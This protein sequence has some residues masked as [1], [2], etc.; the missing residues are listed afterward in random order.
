MISLQV[1]GDFGENFCGP[2]GLCYPDQTVTIPQIFKYLQLAHYSAHFIGFT[3]K[4]TIKFISVHTLFTKTKM[5]TV[6]YLS[7]YRVTTLQRSIRLHMAL[8]I[9]TLFC[10]VMSVLTL[11]VVV[12]SC[13]YKL[14]LCASNKT[15]TILQ[16][17]ITQFND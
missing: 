7:I 5:P 13:K 4:P 9:I 2:E 6:I 14:D 8:N 12:N 16:Q 1:A 15:C 11:A 17:N 10:F 3:I